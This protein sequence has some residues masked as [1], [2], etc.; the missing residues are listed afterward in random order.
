MRTSGILLFL[1]VG[2]GLCAGAIAADVKGAS[3]PP[4]F[5]RFE[6][7]EIARFE[8]N[9][10][11]PYVL[12]RSDVNILASLAFE[13]KETVEGE[14]AR[15]VYLVPTGHSALE[16]VRNYEDMLTGLGFKKTIELG[17]EALASGRYFFG[18]FYFQAQRDA[19][20]AH[21]STPFD[22][23]QNPY[24]QTYQ[25]TSPDG[26][27]VTVALLASESQG[28]SW[29]PNG[30]GGNYVTIAPG[31][32]VLGLDVITGKAIQSKMVLV[33]AS[34]MAKALATAGKIA[35]YGIYFDV[36][37]SDIKPESNATISEIATLLKGDPAL[38]LEIG[39]HT[40]NT[41]QPA[42]NL[43]LSQAR[44]DAVMKSLVAAGIDAK[45]LKAVGYGDSKP[46]APN[47]TDDGKAKNRRVELKKL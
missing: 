46:V 15:Y 10:Y 40:D 33:K 14:L 6:G 45:R 21:E 22:G 44:A 16:V 32:V 13:K 39:G 3:D 41:G 47:T 17:P 23:S 11:A 37:K 35:L 24:Y 31:Q 30:I 1:I 9:N 19:K 26:R 36:D 43:K 34:D 7:S 38:K 25:G 29:L 27:K 18:D 2:A 28:L 5:K 20:Y 42:H 8:K 12:A 4:D